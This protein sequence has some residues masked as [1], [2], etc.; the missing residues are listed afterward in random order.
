MFKIVHQSSCKIPVII[1]RFQLNFTFL[2]RFSKKFQISNFIKIRPVG[3][4][5]FHV[6]RWTD[7]HDD[8]NSRFSQFCVSA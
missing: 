7:G 6:D 1:V 3:A 8:A 4:E 5:L 2:D